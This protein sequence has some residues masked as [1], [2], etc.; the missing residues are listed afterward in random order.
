MFFYINVN[1][2]PNLVTTFAVSVINVSANISANT[3]T[4][5]PL[6]TPNLSAKAAE[7]SKI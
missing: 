1:K 3:A 6:C 7:L 4:L 2:K 5:A